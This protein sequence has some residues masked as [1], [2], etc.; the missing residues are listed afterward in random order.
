MSK[1][2]SRK[3][4]LSSWCKDCRKDTARLWVAK[5][6][7]EELKRISKS[8]RD[9]AFNHEKQRDY[10]LRVRYGLSQ[11]DYDNLLEKQQFSCAICKRDSRQMT[12]HLHV[13]HCHTTN[14]VRGLL[15][16]PCNVFLGYTQDKIE[17]FE[18]AKEYLQKCK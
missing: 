17:V 10:M 16:A 4:G 8:R 11:I 5:Q 18:S 9:K 7:K 3:N 12:Y 6:D 2:R 1:D 13:D 15:C 14:K